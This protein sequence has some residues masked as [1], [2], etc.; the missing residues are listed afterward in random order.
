MVQ[1]RS[2]S[3]LLAGLL[4]LGSLAAAAAIALR[5][6]PVRVRE[7][8]RN[9]LLVTVDTLRADAL[10]VYGSPLPTSPA[11]DRFARQATVFERA[12]AAWP[13]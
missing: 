3:R 8:G 6:G 10:G 13:I 9:V 7:A 2:T 5:S 11:I 1:S 4:A 12:Y